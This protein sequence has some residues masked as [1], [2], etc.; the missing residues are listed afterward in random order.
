MTYLVHISSDSGVK[1]ITTL[2]EEKIKNEKIDV[3]STVVFGAGIQDSAIQK[4][5]SEIV[6]ELKSNY[7]EYYTENFMFLQGKTAD[8]GTIMNPV[9]TGLVVM[10]LTFGLVT[11]FR[12]EDSVGGD[13]NSHQNVVAETSQT[14]VESL[15]LK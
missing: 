2:S 3:G 10:V 11:K 13:S 12:K 15:K 7:P 8:I 1:F 14:R 4:K 9:G 5:K 6:N